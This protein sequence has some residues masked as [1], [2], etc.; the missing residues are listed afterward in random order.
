MSYEFTP[1]NKV[2]SKK[3][4]F[5]IKDNKIY[6]LKFVGGCPGNLL[7]ISKLL[8]GQDIDKTIEILQGN[9]CGIRGTS[10]ADQLS[11]ALKKYKEEN[12]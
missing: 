11:I 8:E 3:I 5:D 2:C 7:A 1:S 4:S 9:Q 10:C 12:S 6:N